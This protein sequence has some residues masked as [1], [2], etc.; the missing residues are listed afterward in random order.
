MT[1]KQIESTEL[2]GLY[3][4]NREKFVDD[5]GWFDKLFC[6]KATLELNDFD[7]KQIN[8]SYTKEQGTVRGM[9]LQAAP[10]AEKKIVTCIEGSVLD[11]VV[12]LN[13]HSATYKKIFKIELSAEKQ[14][15]LVIPEGFAHGFQTLTN[16]CKLLYAHSQ[17]YSPT[18]ETGINIYDDCL[19][20]HWPLLI[21][22]LSERDKI[23]P[24][25]KDFER[26]H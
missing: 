16:N 19:R 3:V 12:D 13:R 15:S 11:L 2:E 1:N 18:S 24:S 8:I 10:H 25:M 17:V 21:R 7:V 5:R 6:K 9:H 4:V 23:L 20:G 14:N 22:N 26:L